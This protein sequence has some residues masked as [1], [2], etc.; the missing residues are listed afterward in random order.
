[1]AANGLGLAAVITA[2]NQTIT[3]FPTYM[4]GEHDDDDPCGGGGG[5]GG[6]GGGEDGSGGG[7][8]PDTG[9]GSGMTGGGGGGDTGGG[10]GDMDRSGQVHDN[11]GAP[12]AVAWA[13]NSADQLVV[14][15]PEVPAIVVRDHGLD[16]AHVIK[17]PGDLG[18]D[19]GRNVFHQQTKSGLACAS[20]HPE[21]RDDGLIWTFAE[22]GTRRSQNLSG[23]I[24]SRA[25]YHWT[26]DK[27]DLNNLMDDVFAVRMG[28]G[29]PT[30]GEKLAIGPFLDRLP[31]PAAVAGLDAAQVA[32]GKTLFESSATEC[33]KCHADSLMTNNSL[34][35]VGTNGTFKVPSLLGVGARGPWM[36]NGCA[37]TL[38]DRFNPTCGGGD[39]HGKTSQLSSAEIDDLTAY[40]E[41]L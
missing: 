35:D 24:M 39:K 37:A 21:G 15:Y 38:R 18:Y 27:P 29:T 5:M 3:V 7:L 9:S 13:H 25:P 32:R 6:G 8:P 11:L 1:M 40:L 28:G 33:T 23:G 16:N 19:A 30:D 12:T 14:F 34:N 31:A 4:L 10:G 22:F 20:C 17:L 2:G 41:S 26:G 36:H